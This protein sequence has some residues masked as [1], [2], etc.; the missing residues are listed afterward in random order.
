MTDSASLYS[1]R[2]AEVMLLIP[3]YELYDDP[4]ASYRGESP[5]RLFIGRMLK[6]WGDC[7]LDVA[8]YQGGY[9]QV[10]HTRI[11]DHLVG[12]ITEVFG[13]LNCSRRLQ[14]A[15]GDDQSRN[16]L[17]NCDAQILRLLEE[18]DRIVHEIGDGEDAVEWIEHDARSFYRKLRVLRQEIE[19]R[20]DLLGIAPSRR[21]LRENDGLGPP[22]ANDGS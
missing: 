18:C 20:N 19:S 15:S 5:Y 10:G 21:S 9:L 14:L 13:V 11:V 2:L 6:D 16:T 8:E 3:D 7:L 4:E 22:H 1:P 12:N 17:V